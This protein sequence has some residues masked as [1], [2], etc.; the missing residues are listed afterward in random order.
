MFITYTRF[1]K[2]FLNGLIVSF[3]LTPC[4]YAGLNK[5]VDEKGHVHYGDRVPSQYLSKEH[6]QLNEQGVTVR[7]SE[8]L[9]TEEEQ[10]ESNKEQRI[11]AAENKKRLIESRT[12]A[13]RDRVLLDTFTTENDLVI[14][15]DARLDA[16]D[17]QISLSETLIK[18]DEIKLSNIKSRIVSRKNR[19]RSA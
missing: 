7:T 17:S 4:A 10:T 18:N 9:K 19:A 12:K 2:Q 16:I 15:R 14:A 11:Q 1:K 13:L 6:S 5:W 8:A 3:L